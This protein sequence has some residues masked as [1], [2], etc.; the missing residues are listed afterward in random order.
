MYPPHSLSAILLSFCCFTGVL[1]I[2][3]TTTCV[4]ASQ[5]KSSNGTAS[6]AAAIAAAFTDCSTNAIIE[7]S[8]GVDYNVFEPVKATSLSNVTIVLKGNLNLPQ[9]I[10]YVQSLVSAAGGSLYWFQLKGTNVQLLGTPDVSG[11]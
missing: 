6:D 1:A 5:Y 4:V 11:R 9:N 10:S 3:N 2:S 7:F 8:E